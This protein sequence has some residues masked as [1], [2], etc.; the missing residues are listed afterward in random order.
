MEITATAVAGRAEIDTSR[1]FQSVREAVEVFSGERCVATG[2]SSRASSSTSSSKFTMM[3][4]AYSSS[5]SQ[6]PSTTLLCCLKKLESDLAEARSELAELKE[7]QSRMEAAV[8]SVSAQLANGAFF[9]GDGRLKK[10][11][12]LAVVVAGAQEEAGGGSDGGGGRVRS[13]LWDE[14]RA[15]QWMASLE[16]LPSLSEALAIKMVEDDVRKVTKKSSNSKGAKAKKKP[17]HQHKK[18]R[19]NAVS[20]VGG[21]FSKRCSR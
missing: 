8:S 1:P 21:I 13:D 16:Y 12:E 17:Q 19:K 3:P 10:G 14:S 7:R 2:G 20:L 15:E 9:S 5:P 4:P 11:K 18:Q 6:Q